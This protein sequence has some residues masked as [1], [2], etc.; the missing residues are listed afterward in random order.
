MP[1]T[2]RPSTSIKN[3]LLAALPKKEYQHLLPGLEKINLD[4]GENIYAAGEQISHVY[5]PESG[6]VSLLSIVD[7]TM[8][9]EVGIVGREGMVGLPV[10]LD[11]KISIN[12][13]V[14]QGSGI[15]WK[16][17]ATDLQ[18]ECQGDGQLPHL[19]KRYTYSL[20]TQTSHTAACNLYH[21]INSRLAR[22][23]LMSHD[24]METDEFQLTQEFLSNMLGVRREAVNKAA[25]SL[26]QQQLISYSR[27][28]IKILDRTGL[29]AVSCECYAIISKEEQLFLQ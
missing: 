28:N 12:R 27:G 5:F 16:M 3:R 1:E 11:V 15:A 21:R 25:A 18:K 2:K 29:E 19:L 9:L 22:W 10:F 23:L 13:A 7:E 6:I 17:K 4:Y 24:R 20:L 14:V 8:M 26:Q